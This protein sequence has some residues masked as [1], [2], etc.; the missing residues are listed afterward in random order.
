ME[1]KYCLFDPI[2]QF[3]DPKLGQFDVK[4]IKIG[5]KLPK[6]EIQV[7]MVPFSLPLR[8]ASPPP[9]LA[10]PLPRFPAS[11]DMKKPKETDAR[12]LKR[13]FVGHTV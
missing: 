13:F 10:S 1:K 11:P 9:C 6:L 4:I 5:Q 2:D 7:I 8:L 12:R 3:L